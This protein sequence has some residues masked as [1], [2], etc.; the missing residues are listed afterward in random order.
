MLNLAPGTFE[1]T[2]GNLA[3]GITNR[4][5]VGSDNRV[6]NLSSNKLNLTFS[7]PAGSF[8]GSIVNPASGKPISF[9]GV[10]LQKPNIGRGFFLGQTQS[11][12]VL[13]EQ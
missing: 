2:G 9:S 8:R 10:V 1:L 3:K 13:I 11:G 6:T 4:I 5:S 12:E 7:T